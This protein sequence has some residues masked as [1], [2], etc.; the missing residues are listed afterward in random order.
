MAEAFKIVRVCR[1]CFTQEDGA[2]DG[3]P[4]CGARG[5]IVTTTVLA[6]HLRAH[7]EDGGK[8]TT[9]RKRKGK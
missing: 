1:Q 5:F 6:E 9:P 8:V 4:V 7:P 2:H 3:C